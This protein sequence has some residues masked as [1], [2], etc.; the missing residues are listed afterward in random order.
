MHF[1]KI[2]KFGE[3]MK[4][5]PILLFL[6]IVLSHAYT[7]AQCA[8]CRTS[9][10]SDLKSGGTIAKGLNSGI[11][12]LMAIPY[13]ILMIGGYFFFKKSVDQKIKSWRMR[14]FPAK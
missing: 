2:L 13:L 1:K 8:M 6:L 3:A 11:L 4:K 10:E 14:Y 7:F 12:Y 9:A 5:K